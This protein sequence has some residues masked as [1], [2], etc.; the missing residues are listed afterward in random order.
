VAEKLKKGYGDGEDVADEA[1]ADASDYMKDWEGL[2]KAKDKRKALYNHFLFLADSPGYDTILKLLCTKVESVSIQDDNLVVTFEA[3]ELTAGPPLTDL[4]PYAHWPASYCAIAAKHR[5]ISFP[6]DGW[7]VVL[8]GDDMKHEKVSYQMPLREYSDWWLYHPTDKNTK[9]EPVLQYLSHEG[10]KPGDHGV[11]FL[12]VGSLFLKLI[13]QEILADEED[14]VEYPE[15]YVVEKESEWTIAYNK[16]SAEWRKYLK[17]R[18]NIKRPK[19][20]RRIG[21]ITSIDIREGSGVKSLFELTLFPKLKQVSLYTMVKGGEHV[22]NLA[23]DYLTLGDWHVKDLG[24][25]GECNNVVKS[26]ELYNIKG[27]EEEKDVNSLLRNCAA[28]NIELHFHTQDIE[29]LPP[30][31]CTM[32]QLT[33]LDLQ[34]NRISMVPDCI[35]G[36]T[37]LKRLSLEE[38]CLSEFPSAILKMSWLEE[39]I[40]DCNLIKELPEDMGK[41]TSLKGLLYLGKNKLTSLPNSMQQLDKLECINLMNNQFEDIPEFLAHMK[42]LRIIYFGGN[43]MSVEDAA[44]KLNRINPKLRVIAG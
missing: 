11:S 14:E 7:A 28:T 36:L 41:M 1:P 3:G 10:G 39:L 43:K 26:V 19:D 27:L 25:V 22:Q 38:N 32:T 2:V 8:E 15:G 20:Y 37:S 4:K 18:Q 24:F 13:G 16:M 30:S 23:L 35:K 42:S 33:S 40:L 17:E 12:S 31:I 9:G 29:E 34:K 44:A 6:E 5:F 21:E